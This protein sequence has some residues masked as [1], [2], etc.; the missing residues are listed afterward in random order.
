MNIKH[1]IV[2]K[3]NMFFKVKKMIMALG[4]VSAFSLFGYFLTHK[5]NHNTLSFTFLVLFLIFM[6]MFTL[7]WLSV[8][9]M[10][11][12]ILNLIEEN[13]KLNYEK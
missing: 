10:K 11:K 9:P 13:Q 5:Y 2:K 7:L 4:T 6:F 3:Y 1:E 12:H 8:K